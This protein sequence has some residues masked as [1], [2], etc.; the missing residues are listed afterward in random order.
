MTRTIPEIRAAIADGWPV[1]KLERTLAQYDRTPHV[2]EAY[3]VSTWEL[4]DPDDPNPPLTPIADILS[5][6]SRRMRGCPNQETWFKS[7][8]SHPPMRVRMT[9]MSEYLGYLVASHRLGHR[10]DEAKFR[11]EVAEVAR[12]TQEQEDEQRRA[13][14]EKCSCGKYGCFHLTVN[15]QVS[16]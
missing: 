6:L 1:S 12:L 2:A 4:R 13:V 3:S 16:R 5:Y 10:D 14:F 9:E 8:E 15:V 7:V 11:A